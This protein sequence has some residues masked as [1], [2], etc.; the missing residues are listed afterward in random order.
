[1]LEQAGRWQGQ[2]HYPAA[3]VAEAA[4][5]VAAVLGVKIG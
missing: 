2:G 3:L 1:M 5:T 4:L